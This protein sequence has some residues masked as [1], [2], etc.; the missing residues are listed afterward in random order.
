M[1]Y[2]VV[3]VRDIIEHDIGEMHDC[4]CKPTLKPDALLV[5]HNAMDNREFDEI[6]K[7]MESDN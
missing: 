5:V 1:C 4:S 7:A 2:H 3:P 6:A